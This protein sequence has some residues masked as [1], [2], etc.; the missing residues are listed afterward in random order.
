VISG[1][2]TIG[3]LPHEAVAILSINARV[4]DCTNG[5]TIT[6]TAV[7]STIG[8]SSNLGNNEANEEITV[9]LVTPC[10]IYLP[11]I[12]CTPYIDTFDDETS[13]WPIE[14]FRGF[15]PEYSNDEYRV[16]T[17][18]KGLHYVYNH[19]F[20]ASS[21]N[22][23]EVEAR[24]RWA[25]T[26]TTGKAYG[27]VFG[28]VDDGNS[29]LIHTYLFQVNADRQE[30]R[31]LRYPDSNGGWLPLTNNGNNKG[32]IET[33]V[34][35]DNPLA[36]NHLKVFW[37]AS[38]IKLSING[39]ELKEEIID[40]KI[41]TGWAGLSVERYDNDLEYGTRNADVYFDNYKF[42]P[43]RTTTDASTIDLSSLIP[44][45]G[46]TLPSTN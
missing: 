24:V 17:K 46:G 27:V 13:G 38:R 43:C 18:D 12:L 37:R 22:N 16:L 32:W 19:I 14:E 33:R 11:I 40:S 2:W 15:I 39:E 41:E 21:Y 36:F 42:S 31:L 5:L 3:N 1:I 4:N 45:A 35:K 25:T 6:N 26:S 23:Y 7:I 9:S 28:L 44:I 29:N 10:Y 20:L 34:I 30:Y 8:Q